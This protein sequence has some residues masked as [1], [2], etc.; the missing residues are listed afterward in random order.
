[1][2][3]A[4]LVF[5][6]R[7]MTRNIAPLLFALAFP[8]L[9]VAIF[10]GIYGNEPSAT[11]DGRGVV[12]ASVP[13]YIVMVICVTGLMSFPLSIAEYRDKRILR[14]FDTTPLTPGTILLAQ[15]ICNVLLTVA[16]VLLLIAVSTLAFGLRGPRCVLLSVGAGL[17]ALVSHYAMGGLI[18]AL[19][20]S[21]RA[22]TVAANLVYF[23]MIFLSGATIPIS[24]FP[25]TMV[26]IAKA[27]PSTYAVDLLQNAWL[28]AGAMDPAVSVGVLVAVSVICGGLSVKL[29]RWQ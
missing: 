8:L 1:M 3:R 10:G 22:A 2:M 11:M 14:R 27:L 19:A 17:L 21:E 26:T 6:I 16:G 7:R 25:D 20:S 23:P 12:D 24:L 29:F 18:A 4:V 5:E 9:M 15:A 28:G 13:A